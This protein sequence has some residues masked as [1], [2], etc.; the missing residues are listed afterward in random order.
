[1]S[2]ALNLMLDAVHH[3]ERDGFADDPGD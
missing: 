3:R 2:A 1:M